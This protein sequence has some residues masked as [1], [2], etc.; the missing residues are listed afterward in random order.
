MIHWLWNFLHPTP[1]F[2]R[3]SKSAKNAFE[4]YGVKTEDIL[5]KFTERIWLIYDLPKFG[6]LH[7]STQ[8]CDSVR[9]I[10]IAPQT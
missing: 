6:I 3:G 8:L 1:N 2:Y 4:A 7:R 10:V 9:P 5:N